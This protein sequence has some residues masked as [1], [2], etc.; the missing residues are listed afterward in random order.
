MTNSRTFNRRIFVGLLGG[1]TA[2]TAI[3]GFTA[4][5]VATGGGAATTT[6]LAD[7]DWALPAEVAGGTTLTIG[8]PTTQRALKLS[9]LDS[10]L[11]FPVTWANLSGGPQTS[12]AF[13][14]K[15]LDLG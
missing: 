6:D 5:C 9:G 14:A 1:L 10:E 2:T 8:D 15:A 4:G 13:R 12:E 11:T 7:P 3:G